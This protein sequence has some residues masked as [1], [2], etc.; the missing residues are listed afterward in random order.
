MAVILHSG[1]WL[2]SRQPWR[3][4]VAALFLGLLLPACAHAQEPAGKRDGL[5]LHVPSPIT[6]A[7]TDGIE[8]PSRTP[9]ARAANSRWSFSIST[10]TNSPAP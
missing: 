7:V 9:S 2:L 5:V 6:E 1:S 3:A 10:W 4:T 8:L